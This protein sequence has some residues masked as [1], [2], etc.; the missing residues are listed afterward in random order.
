M[1]SYITRGEELTVANAECQHIIRLND[2]HSI[3]FFKEKPCCDL[4][5]FLNA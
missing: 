3:T 2:S 1:L 5:I 4:A